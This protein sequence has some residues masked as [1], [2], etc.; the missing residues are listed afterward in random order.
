VTGLDARRTVPTAGTFAGLAVA[1]AAFTAYGSLVPFHFRPRPWD[2]VLGAWQWVLVN[3]WAIDSRSDW[4]ANVLLGMPLG[5]C[6]LGALRVDRP[7]AR[8]AA[9]T[10]LAV[11]PVCVL[12]AAAVE[13]A[14]LYFPGRTSSLSDVVAQGLGSAAGMLGWVL[15]G[16]RLTRWARTVWAGPRLGGTA[17]RVLVAYV[18]LL[19]LVQL[20]PLD[21][22]PRPADLYRKFRDQVTLVPF[23]ELGQPRAPSAG[24]RWAGWVE[25]AALYFPVGLLAAGRDPARVTALRVLALGLL[26]ALV[27]ES[28]QLVVAS[29]SPGVTDVLVGGAA[30]LAGWVVGRRLPVNGRGI[31]PETALVLAQAWAAVVLLI[32]W[33]PFDFD[34]SLGGPRLREL[35][36][37]PFALAY[38]KNYLSSLEEVLAKVLLFAPLGAVAAAV[39]ERPARWRWR[40]VAAATLGAAVAAVVEAGQLYLPTRHPSP[41]DLLLGAAGGW[42][43]AAVALR[44]R[45]AVGRGVR[46]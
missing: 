16:P 11:W 38:E 8:A 10:A 3:R 42:A 14:Q 45:T 22:S 34:G 4:A 37:V 43:G 46:A 21:L 24:P 39:G 40:A 13:F 2:E 31:G 36:W 23:G 30:V 28:L 1:A 29:R 9:R 18:G 32:G 19:A 26:L 41:T 12:F 33:V 44:I 25:L 5:F 27:L 15:A 7:G 20:L 17:G 35:N 6:L